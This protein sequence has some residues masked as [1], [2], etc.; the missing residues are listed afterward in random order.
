MKCPTK[1]ESLYY[2]YK[3]W[4]SIIL[5]AVCDE[6]YSFTL[7]DIGSYDSSNDSGVFSNSNLGCAFENGKMNISNVDPID[8]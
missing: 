8:G 3:G 1:S 2:N 5:L 6:C 7:V 4:F